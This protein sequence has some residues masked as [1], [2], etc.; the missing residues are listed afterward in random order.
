MNHDGRN[1]LL[2]ELYP[3]G[4][5]PSLDSVL[6]RLRVERAA[7]KQRRFAAGAMAAACIAIAFALWPKTPAEKSRELSAPVAVATPVE[8][9]EPEKIERLS[10]EQLLDAVD[11]P[12]ALVML[13]NGQRQLLV[14]EPD[15]ASH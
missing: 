9:K 7:R 8:S 14:L 13:P 6:V 10:D 3:E 12:V 1:D 4:R 15:Q 5:G 11:Q 2:G